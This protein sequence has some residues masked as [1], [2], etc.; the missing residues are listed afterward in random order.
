VRAGEHARWPSLLATEA[1]ADPNPTRLSRAVVPCSNLRVES[2]LTQP[3]APLSRASHPPQVAEGGNSLVGQK[4]YRLRIHNRL[5]L[6]DGASRGASHEPPADI[7]IR[8]RG[9]LKWSDVVEVPWIQRHVTRAT[10]ARI[11]PLDITAERINSAAQHSGRSVDMPRSPSAAR[12]MADGV[13]Y[14]AARLFVRAHRPARQR[15]S[16]ETHRS[17]PGVAPPG[18]ERSRYMP[19]VFSPTSSASRW[20]RPLAIQRSP[21][22]LDRLCGL[23]SA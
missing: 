12:L 9:P 11:A 18:G 16:P 20:K 15:R 13:E 2:T 7:T 21:G 14:P 22:Q 5:S 4:R 1:Q 19:T 6:P 10:S 17:M 8:V 3:P 23:M